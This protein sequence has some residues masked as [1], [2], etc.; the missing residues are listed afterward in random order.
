MEAGWKA[1]RGGGW[2]VAGGGR[3][4]QGLTRRS[5]GYFRTTARQK[6]TQF[7]F[8]VTIRGNRVESR[9]KK[10]KVAVVR[11]G[12]GGRGLLLGSDGDGG[13]C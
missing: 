11:G 10:D 3:C 2:V 13:A 9:E 7:F 1:G 8:Q 4:V 5:A 6:Q 12:A